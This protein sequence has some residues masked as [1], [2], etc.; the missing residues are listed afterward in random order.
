M[1]D[2]NTLIPAGSPIYLQIAN[3]INAGGEIVGFGQTAAGG[4]HGFLLTP[5]GESSSDE[6]RITR[7]V[8]ASENARRLFVRRLGI[9]SR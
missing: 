1:Y 4:L 2:L 6:Q 5:S 8:V 3:S 9:R 7:P